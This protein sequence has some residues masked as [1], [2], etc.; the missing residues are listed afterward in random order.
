MNSEWE[1]VLVQIC[2][3]PSKR[4]RST[5]ALSTIIVSSRFRWK[6]N[7]RVKTSSSKLAHLHASAVTITATEDGQASLIFQTLFSYNLFHRL[8]SCTYKITVLML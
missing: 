8:F 5:V 4:T 3:A 2:L 1:G 6:L 7:I